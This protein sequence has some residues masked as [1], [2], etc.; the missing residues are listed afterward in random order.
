MIFLGGQRYRYQW[1]VVVNAD[2]D[3]NGWQYAFAFTQ[4]A[5]WRHTMDTVQ[6]WVRRRQHHGRCM[7]LGEAPEVPRASYEE[8]PN[9]SSLTENDQPLGPRKV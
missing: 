3:E 6:T 9:E 7:G 1:K 4:D 8:A 5:Q 2:T